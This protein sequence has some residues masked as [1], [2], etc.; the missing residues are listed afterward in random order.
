MHTRRAFLAAGLATAAG[1]AF[2]GCAAQP[3]PVAEATASGTA[4]LVMVI[5][6]AEKPT[7]KGA[8]HGVTPE[9]EQDDESLTVRGW[10]RAGALVD[11]FAAA[12]GTVRAGLVTPATVVAASPDGAS[13]R[14]FQTVSPLAAR[15]GLAVDTS[16]RKGDEAAVGAALQK[17]TDATL[18]AW[19]HEAIPSIVA[20]MGTV[21][22]APPATWP[23]DR[24]DLVW[25][26]ARN[27]TAG[28][29]FSQV[30][31]QLLDGDGVRPA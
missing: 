21:T 29:G 5:R 27:G 19:E 20:A 26:F 11:L 10:T 3:A 6:H 7:G 15:L 14:P 1:A 24:F 28:W 12:S 9:G 22:P 30:T 23:D 2:T 18:V 31:Q 8:P 13:R 25:C 4:P 16:H 17:A